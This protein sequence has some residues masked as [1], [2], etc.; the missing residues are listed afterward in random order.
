MDLTQLF[1]FLRQCEAAQ[2]FVYICAKTLL[3]IFF[4]RFINKIV[5][6]IFT[7]FTR[8]FGAENV[9]KSFGLQR[10]ISTS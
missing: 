3:D 8:L 7:Q 10:E 4:N 1:E 9:T 5:N 6:K 2:D